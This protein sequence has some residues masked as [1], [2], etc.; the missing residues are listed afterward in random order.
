MYESLSRQRKHP[1]QLVETFTREIEGDW[2]KQA[3]PLEVDGNLLVQGNIYKNS[4]PIKV[5]GDIKCTG[6]VYKNTD[7][8]VTGTVFCTNFYGN[9][10]G[11]GKVA[12]SGDHQDNSA[13]FEFVE[14]PSNFGFWGKKKGGVIPSWKLRYFQCEQRTKELTYWTT[15]TAAERG[16]RD[17]SAF[18]GSIAVKSMDKTLGDVSVLDKSGRTFLLRMENLEEWEELELQM[19]QWGTGASSRANIKRASVTGH[20]ALADLA[21]FE[22]KEE[23]RQADEEQAAKEAEKIAKQEAEEEARKEAAEQARKRAAEQARKEAEEQARREAEELAR[24]EAGELAKREAEELAKRE[25]EEQTRQEAEKEAEVQAKRDAE[26]M[27]RKAALLGE[28]ARKEAEEQA[29]R[30]T[31]ERAQKAAE[32]QAKRNVEEQ[33]RRETLERSRKEAEER[34]RKAAQARQEAEQ[35]TTA[36]R[37]AAATSNL[38]SRS[39]VAMTAAVI[40]VASAASEAVSGAAQQIK[41]EGLRLEE[42]QRIK[43]RMYERAQEHFDLFTRPLAKRKLHHRRVPRSKNGDGEIP[44]GSADDDFDI[45]TSWVWERCE[46]G[47]DTGELYPLNPCSTS[48]TDLQDFGAGIALYFWLLPRLAVL[49]FLVGLMST[50]TMSYYA[51]ALTSSSGMAT[52]F[53]FPTSSSDSWSDG[54]EYT[55]PPPLCTDTCYHSNDGVCDDGGDGAAYTYC[56]LGTDC[57]DC[58][59]RQD[60]SLDLTVYGAAQ[61][62]GAAVCTRFAKVNVSMPWAGQE[63]EVQVQMLVPDCH[64]SWK[65]QAGIGL[66]VAALLIGALLWFSRRSTQLLKAWDRDTQMATDFSLVVTNPNSEQSLRAVRAALGTDNGGTGPGGEISRDDLRSPD[67]W[68]AFFSNEHGNIPVKAAPADA[69][70]ADTKEE[71]Q[72]VAVTVALGNGP[73]LRRL[74]RQKQLEWEVEQTAPGAGFE[75]G[76]QV[77]MQLTLSDAVAARFDERS[78]LR[79]KHRQSTRSHR[80][81]DQ[82]SA[83]DKKPKRAWLER[84]VEVAVAEVLTHALYPAPG[85]NTAPPAPSTSANKGVKPSRPGPIRRVQNGVAHR[86][87]STRDLRTN[88]SSNRI[89]RVRA[90]AH[91]YARSRAA[92]AT[93]AKVRKGGSRKLGVARKQASG[94]GIDMTTAD[95]RVAMMAAGCEMEIESGSVLVELVE[96]KH[97]SSIHGGIAHYTSHTNDGSQGQRELNWRWTMLQQLWGLQFDA[98]TSGRR[99]PQVKS[100]SGSIASVSR[101]TSAGRSYFVSRS[102]DSHVENPLVRG[103]G[104]G[105]GGNG[106]NGNTEAFADRNEN[107]DPTTGVNPTTGVTVCVIVAARDQQEAEQIQRAMLDLDGGFSAGFGARVAEEMAEAMEDEMEQHVSRRASMDRDGDTPSRVQQQRAAIEMV[108]MDSPKTRPTTKSMHQRRV[109]TEVR[110]A[111]MGQATTGFA[112]HQLE[113]KLEKPS[114]NADPLPSDGNFEPVDRARKLSSSLAFANSSTR[115]NSNERRSGTESTDGGPQL[116]AGREEVR[117]MRITSDGGEDGQKHPPDPPQL[118]ARRVARDAKEVMDVTVLKSSVEIRHINQT[119]GESAEASAAAQPSGWCCATPSQPSDEAPSAITSFMQMMGIG[120]DHAYWRRQLLNNEQSLERMGFPIGAESTDEDNKKDERLSYTVSRVFVT[121]D[122]EEDAQ[123]CGNALATGYLQTTPLFPGSGGMGVERA[124]EP[125]EI[126][127]EN[128]HVPLLQRIF[129]RLLTLSLTIVVCVL[130]AVLIRS[131]R[132]H[133]DPLFGLYELPLPFVDKGLSMVGLWISLV[134][135]MLPAL[136]LE[137]VPRVEA[138]LC[139]GELQASLLNLLVVARMANSAIIYFLLTTPSPGPA[140]FVDVATGVYSA[141]DTMQEREWGQYLLGERSLQEIQS[142]LIADAFVAPVLRLAFGPG[143]TVL[144]QLFVAPFARTQ[145]RMNSYFDGVD[146]HIAERYTDMIKTAFVSLFYLALLPSGAFVAAY[147]LAASFAVD[148]YCLFRWWKVPPKVDA[149]V[150]VLSIRWLMFCVLVHIAISLRFFAGAP[151]VTPELCRSEDESGSGWKW[152]ACA[153]IGSALGGGGIGGGEAGKWGTVGEVI[154]KGLPALFFP[155]SSD[156]DGVYG[157]QKTLVRCYLYA[158]W[159]FLGLGMLVYVRSIFNALADF[160]CGRHDVWASASF[161][162]T[163]STTTQSASSAGAAPSPGGGPTPILKVPVAKQEGAKKRFTELDP[164]AGAATAYVPQLDAEGLPFPVLACKRA[165]EPLTPEEKF[166]DE[167]IGWGIPDAELDNVYDERIHQ[168]FSSIK[169]WRYYDPTAVGSWVGGSQAQMQKKESAAASPRKSVS[170]GEDNP[171]ISAVGDA[172]IVRMKA[173]I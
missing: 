151:F 41:E 16:D 143:L 162:P 168:A 22:E 122:T 60:H 164:S 14:A 8:Q 3:E 54:Y 145:P 146:W 133:G 167:Y 4:G 53:S 7:L 153:A 25:A 110:R 136:L 102:V 171:Q 155:T 137:L 61:M 64:P 5:N 63:D 43:R 108:E 94:G 147:A 100:A 127:F 121:F 163:S 126:L 13:S 1:S 149:A 57:A 18:K 29:E 113:N 135:V 150:G 165:T 37:L 32:E 103:A 88:A 23:K 132:D 157:A 141:S 93:R 38:V 6:E 69:E 34:A 96:R 49:M 50:P 19:S 131:V 129:Y 134:N 36:A 158:L 67:L 73:L 98:Q 15:D 148:K 65:Q 142:I 111:S 46:P 72:V 161:M 68:R 35:A 11:H 81:S 123:R 97:V 170:W 159:T 138:H 172:G 119:M 55:H 107:E 89:P 26:E 173:D 39:S 116:E 9:E 104:N 84:M 124:S 92:Q 82:S 101:T 90:N 21:F 12:C 117:M 66:G 115:K 128:L 166:V 48:A 56:K 154:T 79:L 80:Q 70:T 130:A 85:N 58:G 47:D 76:F 45:E 27:I 2:F 86:P 91:A 120:H 33:S 74:G 139:Y 114:S 152:E 140:A 156:A 71:L 118:L 105:N 112:G 51:S 160:A 62:Y 78:S 30:A 75:R 125:R 77:A 17:A 24:R 20:G 87:E 169:F 59:G 31:A 144:R 109:S 40:G 42:L 44:T 10:S 95:G 28:Q 83:G 99:P 106:G 52:A